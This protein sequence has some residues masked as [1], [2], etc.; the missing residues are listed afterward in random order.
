MELIIEKRG[1]HIFIRSS[2]DFSMN[3]MAE[4]LQERINNLLECGEK[5]IVIDLSCAP[6]IDSAVIGAI[7]AAHKEA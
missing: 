1:K 3:C 4:K 2:R 7:I 5:C 6:V